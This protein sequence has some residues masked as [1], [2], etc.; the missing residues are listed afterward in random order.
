V[1]LSGRKRSEPSRAA[2]SNPLT[3]EPVVASIVGE[4]GGFKCAGIVGVTSFAGGGAGSVVADLMRC[5]E[6]VATDIDPGASCANEA[7]TVVF[8]VRASSSEAKLV[9]SSA[10]CD[11]AGEA[12]PPCREGSCKMS[13]DFPAFFLSFLVV[14]SNS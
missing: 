6:S 4:E 14:L 10:C 11:G 5:D 9:W 7:V 2:F 1:A 13:I 12:D 3:A 8:E